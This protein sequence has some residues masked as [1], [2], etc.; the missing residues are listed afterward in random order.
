MVDR[1]ESATS[2]H[3]SNLIACVCILIIYFFCKPNS[4][5]SF[6]SVLLTKDIDQEAKDRQTIEQRLERLRADE[7]AARKQKQMWADLI[8]LLEMKFECLSDEQQ[9][10]QQVASQVKDHLVLGGI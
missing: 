7:A 4:I 3:V 9:Q 1:L 10:A 6:A 2:G 5:Y 8:T